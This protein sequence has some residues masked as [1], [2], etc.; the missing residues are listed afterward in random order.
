MEPVREAAVEVL[1]VVHQGDLL[2]E[3]QA[4]TP[5]KILEME[6]QPVELVILEPVMEETLETAETVLADM[7][8]EAIIILREAV[9]VEET[10]EARVQEMT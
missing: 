2:E 5:G 3:Q 7:V 6:L 4:D 8:R 1:L 9:T 10:M